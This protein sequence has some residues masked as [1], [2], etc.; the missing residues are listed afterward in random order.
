MSLDVK[1]WRKSLLDSGLQEITLDGE[2]A[3]L[4]ADLLDFHGDPA[5]RM[6]TASSIVHSATLCTADSKIL[7]WKH[8]L[9]RINASK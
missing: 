2:Q 4:S 8:N 7:D 6:I 3:I 9:A 5:D 1:Y